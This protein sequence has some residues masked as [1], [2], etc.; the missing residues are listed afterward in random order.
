[1]NKKTISLLLG[2]LI[3]VAV[4]W[5]F[6]KQ[7]PPR[8]LTPAETRAPAPLKIISPDTSKS[9]I[10]P[11]DI[12][13]QPPRPETLSQDPSHPLAVSFGDDPNGLAAEPALLME[14]FNSYR[15]HFGAFP[16]GEDNPQIMNA[17]MG[18]NPDRLAIFPLS[19][20]RLAANGALLDAWKSP[21]FFHF[22]SKDHMEIRS[23]GPDREIYTDD[24]IVVSNRPKEEGR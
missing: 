23:P 3:L 24:D 19:H 7:S 15:S 20:P 16:S 14:I 11:A 8:D 17:L 6:G 22:I 9:R 2:L 12:A 13:Q 21:F 10:G 4:S 1:M 5:H 18:A